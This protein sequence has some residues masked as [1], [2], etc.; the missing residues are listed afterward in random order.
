MAS[1]SAIE[2]LA[3]LLESGRARPLVNTDRFAP[4]AVYDL[5]Y[6]MFIV[7]S[8]FEIH[9]KPFLLGQRRIN[10]ARLKLFQ[11]V[12]FRPWLMP[13]IRKWSEDQGYAQ[14]SILSPQQLRRG[15]LGDKMHEDVVEFLVARNIFNRM[16][17]HLATGPNASFLNRLS[18]IGTE[19]HLFSPG[20]R[21][22]R[23]LKEVKITNDMLE[24]W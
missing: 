19:N 12:A 1:I 21:V 3:S 13:V 22:L 14:Q 23:E 16:E 4:S 17:S 7:A 18:V 8:A 11:F 9:A 2:T 10:S 24:G 5:Q 15:F 6:R 20:I